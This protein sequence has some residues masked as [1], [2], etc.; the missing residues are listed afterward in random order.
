M[1]VIIIDVVIRIVIVIVT[2]I[3]YYKT[4]HY[5]NCFL[6]PFRLANLNSNDT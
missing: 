2:I 4:Q 3:H 5:D 1:S 6:V